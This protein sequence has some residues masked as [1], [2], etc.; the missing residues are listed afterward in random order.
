[1]ESEFIFSKA[2]LADF[3]RFWESEVGKKYIDKMKRTKEQLFEAAMGS[4]DPNT[5]ASYAHIANGFDSV[6]K[7]IDAL[8][9]AAEGKKEAKAKGTK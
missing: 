5:S 1:M 8:N 2:E 4:M 9:K 7:D 3:K 6:L